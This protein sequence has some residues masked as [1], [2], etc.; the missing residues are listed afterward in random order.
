MEKTMLDIL[1]EHLNLISN[2]DNARG[3]RVAAINEQDIQIEAT[4]NKQNIMQW[5]V[6]T[7]PDLVTYKNGQPEM[8]HPKVV[9][10]LLDN[11]PTGTENNAALIELR[12]LNLGPNSSENIVKKLLDHGSKK[13]P[14]KPTP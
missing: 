1:L 8:D 13:T 4:F 6:K 9:Q 14:S 3:K 5:L 2:P 12:R 10:F 11:S 7:H